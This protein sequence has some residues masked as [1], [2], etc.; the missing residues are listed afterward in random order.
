MKITTHHQ[1]SYVPS[2]VDCLGKPSFEKNIPKNGTLF[3]S[4]A[5][6]TTQ[7][8][9]SWYKA[10]FMS[11]HNVVVNNKDCVVRKKNYNSAYCNNNLTTSTVIVLIVNYQ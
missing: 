6:L 10:V 9:D 5:L 11:T 3:S 1:R 8:Q 2:V 7:N 4:L